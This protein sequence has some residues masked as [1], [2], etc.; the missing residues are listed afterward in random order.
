[1]DAEQCLTMT[2]KRQEYNDNM[3]DARTRLLNGFGK[4]T[5]SEIAEKLTNACIAVEERP[6]RAA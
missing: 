5:T 6:L 4:G 2:A 1:M 3:P